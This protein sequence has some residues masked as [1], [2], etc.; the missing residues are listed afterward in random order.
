MVVRDLRPQ[1][2]L[3]DFHSQPRLIHLGI[4]RSLLGTPSTEPTEN[5]RVY[6]FQVLC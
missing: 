6:N 3:M 5:Q 4:M 2:I 1:H